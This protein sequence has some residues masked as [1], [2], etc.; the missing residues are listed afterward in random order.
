MSNFSTA[1]RY[2][3]L[4]SMLTFSLAC[5][6]KTDDVAPQPA[7][8]KEYHLALGNPSSATNSVSNAN[9]Y[10]MVKPQ[11]ILAY[12][13]STQRANWVAWHLSSDWKGGQARTDNFR[14][15][16]DL[17]SGWYAAG[18]SAYSGTGYDRGHLC[19]ADD[20]D[21][22]YDD[23][24]ATFLMTNMLPQTPNLNRITWLGLEDYCRTLV[25]QGNECYIIAGPNGQGG[26]NASGNLYGTVDNGRIVVPATCWKVVLVIPT[27]TDDL[28][29]I[30]Q[31]TRVIAVN[32]PNTVNV[33]DH[34]WGYYRTSVRDI[35]TLTGLHFFDNLGSSLQ[36][37]IKSRVDTGATS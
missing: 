22:S 23:M 9:N 15:D 17:P 32:M 26:E 35:E 24:S 34:E 14:A 19:P 28:T 10:L 13:N 37:I 29:R 4:L 18:T 25:G 31:N 1:L 36:Q 16:T 8:N 30:T 20:R 11:Y 12:N 33:R 3:A 5:T 21:G 7:N 2:A 6:R 27:G